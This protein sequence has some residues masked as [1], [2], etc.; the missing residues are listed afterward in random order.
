MSEKFRPGLTRQVESGGIALC[1]D[2]HLAALFGIRVAF[3]ERSGGVSGPPFDSLNLAAHVGDDPRAVDENRRR[4]LAALGLEECASRLT[5]SAQV[6][7][8]H[9]AEVAG[10]LAGRGASA[11]DAY[12]PIPDSDALWT[13]APNTPLLM[14]FADCVP[15]VLVALAPDPA[16]A[17]V[18]AGW[19]GALVSLP[20]SAATALARTIGCGTDAILAY[21][22]PHIGACCYEVGAEIT[23]HFTARFGTIAAADGR[24]DLNAVVC[25]DLVGAGVASDRIARV[26]DCTLDCSD[27]YYSY[28]SSRVTDRKSVV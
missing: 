22:G 11:V 6:H 17:V 26:G 4:L 21:V 2:V 13:R 7:G 16:V 12:G 1:T 15:V 27:R 25:A 18:H 5:T 20:G 24:L 23:S 19:R 3:S 9:I 10:D 8:D 28:R 14:C